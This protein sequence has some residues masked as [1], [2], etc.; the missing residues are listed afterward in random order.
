MVSSPAKANY[1]ISGCS[2]GR[3]LLAVPLALPL[4]RLQFGGPAALE[5]VHLPKPVGMVGSP[6]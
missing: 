1:S 3:A 2:P 4:G 5:F 6:V